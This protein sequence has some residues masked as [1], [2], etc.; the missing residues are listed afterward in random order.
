MNRS[1]G[2]AIM[3][4]WLLLFAA[5]VVVAEDR[6][7]TDKTGKYTVKAEFVAL[8][9]GKVKLKRADNG[10]IIQVPL[11]RLREADRK[12]ALELS[13]PNSTPKP[14]AAK[15]IKLTATVGWSKFP[16]FDADGN[17]SPRDLQLHVEARGKPA[18]EAIEFGFLKVKTVKGDNGVAIKRK[19]EEIVI[20]DLT[21]EYG[22]VD[23]SQTGVFATHPGDGVRM[24]IDLAPPQS[25]QR[26][27]EAKGSFKIKTGGERTTFKVLNAVSFVGKQ[28]ANPEFKDLDVKATVSVNDQTLALELDG[29]HTAIYQVDVRSPDGKKLEGQVGGGSGGGGRLMQYQFFFG[30]MIPANATFFVH[31]AKDTEEVEIP[32]AFTNLKIPPAPR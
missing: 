7:W 24:T 29:E 22:K 21:K 1:T 28:L 26:I 14:A 9:D 20:H 16:K 25:L 11:S 32:F 10:K 5:G 31:V 23:R 2:F 13:K 3:L 4:T 30:E 8:A 12:V 17:Q 18:A 15:G 27:T 6:V 19:K